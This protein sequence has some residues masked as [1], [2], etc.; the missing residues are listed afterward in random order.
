MD[1]EQL[2]DTE[3]YFAE[4]AQPPRKGLIGEMV[5]YAAW[6]Q[7]TKDNDDGQSP[8]NS[9]LASILGPYPYPL[10][11][12]TATVAASLIC[13]LGTNIGK[14]FLNE[15]NKLAASVRSTEDAYRM[16]WAQQNQRRSGTN[17]GW[18]TLELILAE[19][20]QVILATAEEVEAAEQVASWLGSTAGQDFLTQ[21]EAEIARQQ[22]G[23][24]FLHHLTANLNLSDSQAEHV[25]KMAASY[26]P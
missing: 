13:W 16:S 20:G 23:E 2:W 9:T 10:T 24:R 25:L 8:P 12:R 22:H 17:G 26:Q 18:R 4:P 21:C 5:M 1:H 11:Q 15:A 19:N 7:H 6:V 3:H 14:C